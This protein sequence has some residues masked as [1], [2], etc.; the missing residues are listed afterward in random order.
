MINDK[1][2]IELLAPAGDL[3]RL[4]TAVLYGADAVYAGGAEFSL[5]ANAKNFDLAQM[6]EG[7]K[8]CHEHNAKFYVAVNIFAHNRDFEGL[9]EYLIKLREM[10]AD[11]VIVSDPG[12][13]SIVRKT[14]PEMDI[15][16]STQANNTNVN[17]ALFWR[18]LGAKRIVLARE[19]SFSEIREIYDETI[20]T[21]LELE[22]FVHGAM[23]ISYSGRCLLS[24]YLSGR[25]SNQGDC[26]HPC[27]WKYHLVEETRPGQ[28]MPVFEDDR[29]AYFFN[30]K[31]LCMVGN[32]GELINSGIKSFKIEGRMKT[33]YYVAN[34]VKTYRT[35]IDDYL[36]HDGTYEKNFDMYLAEIRKA[37]H[38][39]FTDGFYSGKPDGNQQIYENSTYIRGYDFVALVKGYDE[40]LDMVE[41]EQRNRFFPGDC[42]EVLKVKGENFT[43]IIDEIY[44]EK[45]VSVDSAS[46]AQQKLYIKTSK[47]L[48]EFDMLRRAVK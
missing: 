29:G 36:K 16:I 28:Y 40:K 30:S 41:I 22:A 37:S 23:C 38:R 10:G 31:D 33:L 12:V 34:V 6:Q 5:R 3:E 14:I 35:A 24:N 48:E 45:G 15:H 21:G 42:L 17:S 32:I 47:P 8:F 11:A 20:E 25:D 46:H 27:R 2:E 44:D 26:S 7:I 4:K 18:E 19:L 13:F 39:D 43:I 9:E 1:N